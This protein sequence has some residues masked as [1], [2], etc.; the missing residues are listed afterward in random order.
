MLFPKFNEYKDFNSQE[1]NK[2]NPLFSQAFE[3]FI[4]G[5]RLLNQLTESWNVVAPLIASRKATVNNIK[6][7]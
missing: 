1:L 4:F 7:I 5:L 2:I 3:K 6:K